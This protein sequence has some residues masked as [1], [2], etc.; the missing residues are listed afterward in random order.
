LHK[1]T[2]Y[3]KRISKFKDLFRK[4]YIWTLHDPIIGLVHS[5]A[6]WTHRQAHNAAIMHG[7]KVNDKYG[8][9]FR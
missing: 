2:I 9:W 5:G 3:R 4:R 8:R 7:K 6:S 1:I